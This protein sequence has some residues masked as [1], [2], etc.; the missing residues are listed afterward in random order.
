ML[1]KG[2]DFETSVPPIILVSFSWFKN[3][4]TGTIHCIINVQ[5]AAVVAA[6]YLG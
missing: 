6:T 2:G 5:L 4:K 3:V 1:S